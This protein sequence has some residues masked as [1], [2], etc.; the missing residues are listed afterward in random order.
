MTFGGSVERGQPGRNEKTVRLVGYFRTGVRND[1]LLGPD[2]RMFQTVLA[3]CPS[4]TQVRVRSIMS[5]C[6]SGPDRTLGR[7]TG[8]YPGQRTTNGQKDCPKLNVHYLGPS[9]GRCG[10]SLHA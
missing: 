3:H 8:A 4:T 5:K 10:Q 1:V 9:L 7:P 6:H 2:D